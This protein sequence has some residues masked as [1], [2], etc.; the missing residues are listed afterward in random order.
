MIK[1]KLVAIAR[2]GGTKTY[3]EEGSEIGLKTIKEVQ[4]LPKYYID[5][6]F[7]SKT[8]GELFDDYPNKKGAKI[9]DKSQFIIPEK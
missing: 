5:G 4:A 8:K 9:L 1:L 3:I 6:R 7:G 2:D